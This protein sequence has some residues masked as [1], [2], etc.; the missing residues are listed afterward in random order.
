MAL[1][2][3]LPV[4]A[5]ATALFTLV[6]Q[7]QTSPLGPGDFL[8]SGL[9]RNASVRIMPAPAGPPA[10][11]IAVDLPADFC[12]AATLGL[13]DSG[14]INALDGGV[15]A[16]AGNGAAVTF[17]RICGAAGRALVPIVGVEIV[18]P[19]EAG[20]HCLLPDSTQ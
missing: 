12:G 2:D 3:G 20:N 16:C 10:W 1:R 7:R 8:I 14:G 18:D 4:T 5:S 13:R 11:R 17:T 6:S 19:E 15:A 9:F